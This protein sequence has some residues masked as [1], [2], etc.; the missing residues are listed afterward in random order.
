MNIIQ[1]GANSGRDHVF[2]FATAHREKI[3]KIILVE[4]VPLLEI[5][6]RECYESFPQAIFEMIGIVPHHSDEKMIFYHP[7]VG[8]YETSAFDINHLLNHGCPKDIITSTVVPVM[9]FSELMEKHNLLVI[10]NLFI[11]AEGL[12]CSIVKSIDFK[13]YTI[14]NIQFESEHSDGTRNRGKK[15]EEVVEYLKKNNYDVA[16]GPWSDHVA[17]LKSETA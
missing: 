9:T 16:H 2:D 3:N 13:K 1:I 12:D 17:I 15:L 5:K 10:D 6:L 14:K 4:P 11:D 7:K 8:N